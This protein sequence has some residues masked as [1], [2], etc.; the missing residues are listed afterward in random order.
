[1]DD[2][3]GVVEGVDVEG[4]VVMA[5]VDVTVETPVT[6][7]AVDIEEELTSASVISK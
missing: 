6:V 3:V 2:D 4:S 5:D 1:L 7:E